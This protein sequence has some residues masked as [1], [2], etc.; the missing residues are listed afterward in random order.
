MY[1]TFVL[2]CS[3]VEYFRQYVKDADESY[4]EHNALYSIGLKESIPSNSIYCFSM[5]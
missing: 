5:N 2:Q 4:S 3:L 1:D